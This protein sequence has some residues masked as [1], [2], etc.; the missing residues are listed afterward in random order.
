VPL[1]GG[2]GLVQMSPVC[3]E[4]TGGRGTP[5]FGKEKRRGGKEK[6]CG[7][8]GPCEVRRWEGSNKKSLGKDGGNKCRA[9]GR[10]GRATLEIFSTRPSER[11][12][13]GLIS[14]GTR[15]RSVG[16]K[17]GGGR[18][19]RTVLHYRVRNRRPGRRAG[20]RLEK[21][22]RAWKKTG[23]PRKQRSPDKRGGGKTFLYR[24]RRE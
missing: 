24:E 8:R 10:K 17:G 4:T 7:D 3:A 2:T 11:R 1:E 6:A 23:C 15:S 22:A 13:R 5:K 14:K 12:E 18:E 21:T 16:G 20:C 19:P 9:W